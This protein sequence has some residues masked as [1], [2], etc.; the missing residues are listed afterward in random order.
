MSPE[1]VEEMQ[2]EKQR[3]QVLQRRADGLPRDAHELAIVLGLT[4]EDLEQDAH[5]RH[6]LLTQTS[7]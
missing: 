7:G 3:E 2:R 4:P 5:L 1:A 6:L